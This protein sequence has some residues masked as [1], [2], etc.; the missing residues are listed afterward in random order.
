MKKISIKNH[1]QSYIL[2][3]LKLEKNIPLP[4]NY[5]ESL[6][7]DHPDGDKLK[8]YVR[9]DKK[10]YREVRLEITSLRGAIGAVH[11]YAKLIDCSLSITSIKDVNNKSSL[12]GYGTKNVP[13]KYTD[14][15]IELSR[16]VTQ[17]D[18]D[19]DKHCGRDKYMTAKLGELTRGFW[20]ESEALDTG[21]AVFKLLF[22]GKW[23]LVIDAY[24]F[25]EVPTVYL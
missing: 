24:D 1:I 9:R 11:Y 2:S 20:T 5:G 7:F 10:G 13:E 16:P 17:K 15:R 19:H 14:L 25:E 21:I 23:K 3:D 6:F 18:I 4:D 12:G 8:S 22:K